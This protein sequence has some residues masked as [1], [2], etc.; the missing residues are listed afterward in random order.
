MR[1]PSQN[2][3]G[4]K[5]RSFSNALIGLGGVFL[6]AAVGYAAFALLQ[7]WLLHQNRFLVGQQIAP[8]SAPTATV[9]TPTLTPLVTTPQ[10]FAT[11]RPALAL[12]NQFELPSAYPESATPDMV[13]PL[14][15]SRTATPLV[16]PREAANPPVKIRIPAI[17]VNR[18]IVSLSRM[19]DRQTGAL[20]WNTKSLFRKGRQ[21]LVGHSEGSALAGEGGNMIL[22]GHNYGYGYN[23]VFVRLSR[24]KPGDRV[25]LV[26]SAAQTFTYEV[27]SVDKVKWRR[28]SLGEL[29][30][31]LT[32]LSTGGPERLTLISCAGAE[33]E[34]FPARV[35]VVAEP[36]EQ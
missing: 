34:P 13:A 9:A 36:V 27:K 17:K 10:P 35:Y 8:L 21:D 1:M 15:I 14:A 4:D 7:S 6:L 28:Q 31:H 5:T 2:S 11:D 33:V 29:T 26:D 16:T 23:G 25:Y 3:R 22:V 12:R 32:F 20:T 19:R 18:S 24:L 30:R